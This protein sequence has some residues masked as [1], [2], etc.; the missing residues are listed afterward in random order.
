MHFLLAFQIDSLTL[1]P[2]VCNSRT[3]NP[4]FSL[5]GTQVLQY[6]GNIKHNS[7]ALDAFAEVMKM[8]NHIGQ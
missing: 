2:S 1:Q 6:F 7:A 4:Y 8:T 3:V 5:V